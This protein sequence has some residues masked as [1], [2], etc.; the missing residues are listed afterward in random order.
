MNPHNKFISKIT[1]HSN[2]VINKMKNKADKLCL[3]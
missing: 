1:V 3:Q 2:P